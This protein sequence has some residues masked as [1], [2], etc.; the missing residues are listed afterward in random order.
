MSMFIDQ[1]RLFVRSGDGGKGC[2]SFRR[3]KYIPQ[4]GP[5]GGD[6]GKGGDVVFVVDNGLSTLA[7]QRYRKRYEAPNGQGG[8]GARKTGRDGETLLVPVPPGTVV[9]DDENG[10]ILADLVTPGQR[11]V[12][13]RGGMGGLGNQHFATSTRQTP[14]YAQPGLPGESLWVTLELKLLADVGLVGFPNAGKSTLIGR[15]SRARP[16]VADYP[17]TTLT[18]NLGV[19][20]G[21]EYRTF[22][23]ADIPGLIEG[24]HDGK[25]LGTRFLRHIE[26]TRYLLMMADATG[27][28]DPSPAQALDTLRQELSAYD[29][30]LAERP[31][32]VAATKA[33]AAEGAALAEIQ[34]W[35]KEKGV[36]FF[37]ISAVTG[38]GI[39]DLVR[40]LGDTVFALREQEEE[41]PVPETET[42]THSVWDD[43]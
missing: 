35:A 41:A 36:P 22:V 33:D 11:F 21:D 27:M 7:E 26:R 1:T 6:G 15:I 14:R 19:V 40:H 30:H 10:E 31:Y 39:D 38:D 5:D 16:K 12:I 25:G 18:P 9:K 17:F 4:G 32:C 20:S 23:V 8:S 43:E 42:S 28:A 29:A 2:V 24:A 37:I 13:A 3:E 34:D